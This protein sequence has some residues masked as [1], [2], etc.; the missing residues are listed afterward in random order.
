ML[1]RE[2]VC[3][4]E[5]E[6]V[7]DELKKKGIKTWKKN[8]NENSVSGSCKLVCVSGENNNNNIKR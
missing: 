1:E 8:G 3:I 6:L 5:E 4:R 2:R 7:V